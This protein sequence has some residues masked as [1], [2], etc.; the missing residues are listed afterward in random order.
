MN[1]IRLDAGL[2][3]TKYHVWR[4]DR[5]HMNHAFNL[6]Y[7][8]SYIPI[9]RDHCDQSIKEMSV[10]LDGKPFNLLDFTAHMII[11]SIAKTTMNGK[12]EDSSGQLH[13]MIDG[14]NGFEDQ[15]FSFSKFITFFILSGLEAVFRRIINPIYRPD[16][17]YNRTRLCKEEM[18]ARKFFY[19]IGDEV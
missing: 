11:Q 16:W 13:K 15:F 4:L 2:L 6:N 7:I 8:K 17:I 10:H 19:K 14:I 1:F 5:K 12:I 18:D 9:F 3:S